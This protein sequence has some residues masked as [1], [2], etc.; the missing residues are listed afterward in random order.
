MSKQWAQ[1]QIVQFIKALRQQTKDLPDPLSDK[2]KKE[3]H[4]DPY[5]ML[6]SC[7]LSLRARDIVTYPISVELFKYAKTP[8]Q[9]VEL[10]I[11]QLE[12]II[13]GAGFYKR[14]AQTIVHVSKELLRRFHGKVPA[15]KEGLLS[16]QGI[17]PK[18][19]NLVLGQVFG[20]PAI[21]VDT[22][23]HKLANAF[24]LVTT[25]TPAQTEKA[26]EKIV[27]QKYW[28]ELNRLL[29][30]LGQNKRQRIA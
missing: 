7:L 29:V 19:A 4:N 10:P 22:H 17:G 15:S 30:K 11:K 2:I 28:I 26:L 1:E 25:K 6:I 18:T 21:C 13:R 3:Y 24:G 14:K 5:L 12:H 8:Q 23:V 20:I 9:M 16:I 27:P